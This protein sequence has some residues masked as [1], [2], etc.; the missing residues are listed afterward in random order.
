[1]STDRARAA[2]LAVVSA[3]A[4]LD[5]AGLN[6]AAEGNVSVRI[7]KGRFVVSP[8]GLDKGRLDAVD[9]VEVGLDGAAPAAAS[10]EALMHREIYLRCPAVAAV[11]HAH[12][13]HVQ[14]LST[15]NRLPDWQLL[16]EGAQL[17]GRVA[18]VGFLEPGSRALADA[19]AEALR[20]TR[21]CVLDRHGAVTAA[22]TIDEALLLM[23]L[24]E[25]LAALTAAHRQ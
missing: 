21:A 11:V 8:R 25:R 16:A 19:V 24:L 12:P 18:W 15:V 2:R 1:V 3:A 6:L 14:A 20:Q 17:L 22:A 13:H 4:R 23:M 7:G 5:D 10:S 9:V